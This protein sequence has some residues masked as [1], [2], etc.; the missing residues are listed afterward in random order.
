MADVEQ[1]VRAA[2]GQPVMLDFYADWCVT[3]KELERYT[4]AD[5]AVR[6]TLARIV[7]LKADVTAHDAADRELLK[8]FGVIGPPAI[9]FFGPD[10]RERREYRVVGFMDA[11]RF[12]EHLRSL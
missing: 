2:G 4:F 7:T 11:G 12:D 8:H 6:A 9:L 1:A 5:P 3:C 10:G